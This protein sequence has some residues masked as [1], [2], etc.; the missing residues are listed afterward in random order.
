MVNQKKQNQEQAR[1]ELSYLQS[2][3]DS[4]EGLEK[5]FFEVTVIG[6]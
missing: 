3:V 2:I 5:H 1:E 4:E 6:K